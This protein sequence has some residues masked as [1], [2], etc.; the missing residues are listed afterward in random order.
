MQMEAPVRR[1]THYYTSV[2]VLKY[3]IS[4]RA[5]VSRESLPECL[6][7]LVVTC[8]SMGIGVQ[9]LFNKS[10]GQSCYAL[11]KMVGQTCP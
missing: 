3:Y 6:E 8:L 4:L 11:R 5:Q 7:L 2:R 10:I 9:V 1:L